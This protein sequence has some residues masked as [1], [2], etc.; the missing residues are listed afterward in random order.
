MEQLYFGNCFLKVTLEA[1]Q[2]QTEV[3]VLLKVPFRH[4]IHIIYQSQLSRTSR[5]VM[6]RT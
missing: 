4:N 6:G 1:T 5:L 3:E 2:L